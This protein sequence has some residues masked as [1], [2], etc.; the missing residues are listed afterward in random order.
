M[1]L[2]IG[3]CIVIVY[4]NIG[5][6]VEDFIQQQQYGNIIRLLCGGSHGVAVLFAPCI[7]VLLVTLFFV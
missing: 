7:V 3:P 4:G 6:C 5:L 1:E 2:L